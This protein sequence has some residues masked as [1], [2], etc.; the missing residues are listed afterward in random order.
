MTESSNREHRRALNAALNLLSRRDHSISELRMKLKRKSFGSEE[1]DFA[2]NRLMEMEYLDDT[3]FAE[4][5]V[6]HC[7]HI[8]KLGV[9]RIRQELKN[10]GLSEDVIEKALEEYSPEDEVEIIRAAV[11]SRTQAGKSRD[12]IIRYLSGKGF[13]YGAIM[14]SLEESTDAD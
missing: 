8:R 4:G 3:G 14:E 5:L 12:S 7:Q 11:E 9:M 2:V 13:S 10:K 6:R 1:I